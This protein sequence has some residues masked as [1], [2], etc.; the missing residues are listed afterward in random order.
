[1]H[2][3]TAHRHGWKPLLVPT[4]V[5]L[6]SLSAAATGAEPTPTAV[7]G[8]TTT[9]PARTTVSVH[10]DLGGGRTQ[11]GTGTVIAC[12]AGKSL[13]LTNAHVAD[14][15]DGTYTVTHAGSAYPATYVA[16]SAISRVTQGS[17]RVD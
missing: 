1:M 3:T 17:V 12:E 4:T 15:P 11:A 8:K 10:R 9:D 5:L 16:G 7:A 2:R 14:A 13:I 6:L